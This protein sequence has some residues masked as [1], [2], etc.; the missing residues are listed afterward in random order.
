[1]ETSLQDFLF[2]AFSSF[3]WLWQWPYCDRLHPDPADALPAL[4]AYR[5]WALNAN[6]CRRRQYVVIPIEVFGNL[7]R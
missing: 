3:S 4:G 7:H 2:H 6:I 5:A 1:M